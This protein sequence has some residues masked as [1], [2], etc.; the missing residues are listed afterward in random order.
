MEENKLK[1]FIPPQSFLGQVV[2]SVEFKT[3][4]VLAEEWPSLLYTLQGFGSAPI[5][6][7]RS[8]LSLSIK[9]SWFGGAL[10]WKKLEENFSSWDLQWEDCL[11][12]VQG[13]FSFLEA[14]WNRLQ[15]FK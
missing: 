9:A 7:G 13:S 11:V 15:P 14:Q 4:V 6:I 1:D 10:H 12:C 2:S 3:F 8:N 5:Y